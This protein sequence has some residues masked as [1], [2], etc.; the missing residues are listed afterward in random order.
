M[1]RYYYLIPLMTFIVII[2]LFMVFVLPKIND[3]NAIKD[4]MAQKKENLAGLTEKLDFL[5][6]LDT[7][8]LKKETELTVR[9]LPSDKDVPSFMTA[10]DNLSREASTS[11]LSVQGSPGSVSTASAAL[12]GSV[13]TAAKIP[14]QVAVTGSFGNIKILMDK[15]AQSLPLVSIDGFVFTFELT[16]GTS[17]NSYFGNTQAVFTIS[18]YYLLPP[19]YLG[20]VSSKIKKIDKGEER[21]LTKLSGF[22]Y[23]QQPLTLIKTGRAD[24]FAKF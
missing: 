23:F 13:S 1:K 8:Q 22:S 18:S 10:L 17:L 2:S 5:N 7:E 11:V 19:K 3:I 16:E 15:I 21:T 24:P 9:A 12:L 6:S 4:S 20:K 14:L